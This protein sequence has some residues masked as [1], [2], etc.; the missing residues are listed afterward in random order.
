MPKVIR[1]LAAIPVLA[2]SLHAASSVSSTSGGAAVQVVPASYNFGKQ[3]LNK[4]YPA[5]T[6]TVSNVGTGIFS[7]KSFSVTGPFQW[8]SGLAPQA[9]VVGHSITLTFRFWPTAVGAVSGSLILTFND[10]VPTV[11]IPLSGT[12]A[13]TTGAISYN[14]HELVFSNQTVG[15]QSSQILTLTNT[16]EAAVTVDTPLITPAVF[17]FGSTPTF[18]L[19]LNPGKATQVTV[20]YA[21]VLPGTQKGTIS[22]TFGSLPF[23]GVGLSGTAIAATALTVATTTPIPGPATQ[24]AL[25]S[26]QLNA[27]G[28]TPPYSWSLTGGA[29]PTG[30]TLS[31]PGVISGTPGSIATG[32]TFAVQVMDAKGALASSSMFLGVDAPT[33]A[34]CGQVTWDITGTGNP[35]IPMDT[36]GTGTYLGYEGGLYPGGSNIEPA[37]HLNSGIA[38]ANGIQPLDANGNPSSTG[39][40]V[41][42]SLGTSDANYE[43]GRFLEYTSY[44]STLNPNLV[45]V[46]GAQGAEALDTLLGTEA[47][48]FWSNITDWALPDAGVTSQQVVAIWLEPEDANPPG[49]FPSDAQQIQNELLTLIPN[50]LVR[51]PSL[52]LLY[53]SSRAYSG[54]ANPVKQTSEPYAYDQGYA[55]QAIVADQINGDPA[56]NF[57]PN[58]GAV[59]APWLSWESYKWGNGMTQHNGLVWSCQD[60]R[61]DGYH[62]TGAGED[63]V[64]GLLMNFLKTDP[65]AAPWFYVPSTTKR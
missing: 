15:S 30:L 39:K 20:N 41:L 31:S 42:L 46:Q 29:L 14:T 65:T 2:S 54:Y 37:A 16:G 56:L 10:G 1:F 51:F 38:I 27:A 64:S 49:M 17:S 6:F 5:T 32:T 48:A 43:F 22:F 61:F 25:Y 28:G 3:F 63:K 55:L 52:K 26:Y 9:I 24:S 7:L 11:T 13:T 12:G 23:S 34:N 8:A 4:Q 19:T 50:L 35:E 18:P 44:E 21:P 58:L 40:Y 53:L 62:V 60:F 33:G 45:L 36:L 59:V 47:N 57:N